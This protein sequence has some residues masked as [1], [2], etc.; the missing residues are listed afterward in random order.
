MFDDVV[1]GIRT[2]V[3]VGY[4]T[5]KREET[6]EGTDKKPVIRVTDWEPGEISLVSIPADDDVG[7]GRGADEPESTIKREVSKMDEEEEKRIAEEARKAEE[8]RRQKAAKEEEEKRAAEIKLNADRKAV[9]EGEIKRINEIRS[10]GERRNAVDLAQEFIDSGRSVD[11]F[12]TAVLDQMDTDTP[13]APA[14]H[15]GVD[16]NAREHEGYSIVRAMRASVTGDWQDAGLEREVSADIARQ[17]GRGTEGIFVP[18]TLRNTPEMMQRIA[19]VQQRALE[20]GVDGSGGYTVQTNVMTLIEM[21]RNRMMVRRMGARVLSGLEGDLSFPR[22]AT[23]SAFTWTAETPGSDVADSDVSLDQVALTPKSGQ[24]STAYSRQLLNQSSL[25]IE[26][27]VRNDLTL[28][29]AIGIDLAALHGT[30]ASNQPTGIINVTGIGDVPGGANGLAPTWANTVAL[31]T[32]VATDN[33]DVGALGYLTN[34]KV[35]GTMKVT[36]KASGTAK[37]LWED[38]SDG[39]GMVN[40]YRA[41]VSNQASST[42]TK[43]T[44]V[45]V[46][47]ANFFGNWDDLLIGEWGAIEILLDP[48]SLKKQALIEITSFVM[49][50]IAVRHAQSFSAT[51]DLLTN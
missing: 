27:F 17:L 24:S 36:E 45:G 18:T 16:M 51:K 15:A 11:E 47:S 10:I 31:E 46:C 9:R 12:R 32:A 35:R 3:S 29:A 43:G 21:L 13:P 22:Q 48:Y 26:A 33:A 44:A 7:V 1:D 40:G 39:F 50:D 42:L 14:R 34:A 19:G 4:W 25:D 30:G 49:A 37:F 8:A 20:A 41:G 28:A 5:H 6:D 38:G 2:K 23:G